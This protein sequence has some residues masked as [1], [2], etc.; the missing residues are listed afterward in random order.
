MYR[1]S[2]FRPA[3]LTFINCHCK[4]NAQW[5]LQS[6]ELSW[7][8]RG[9]LGIRTECPDLGP[10]SIMHSIMLFCIFLTTKRVPFVA[11]E[12]R[13][14]S[15]ITWTPFFNSNLRGALS[16]NFWLS[17]EILLWQVLIWLFGTQVGHWRCYFLSCCLYFAQFLLDSLTLLLVSWELSVSS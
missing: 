6:L 8:E 1:G 2:R 10:V 14:R 9:I 12:S 4:L 16:P 17:K 15:S 13:L 7:T 11:G 5:V 3:N